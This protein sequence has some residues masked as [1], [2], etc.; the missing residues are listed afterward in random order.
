[1]SSF[2]EAVNTNVLGKLNRSEDRLLLDDLKFEG[3]DMQV[4][5]TGNLKVQVKQR[6]AAANTSSSFMKCRIPKSAEKK[7][8]SCQLGSK[9]YIFSTLMS[10]RQFPLQHEKQP[11]PRRL[12]RLHK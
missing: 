12:R 5:E 10:N 2:G 6:A 9:S 4:V 11:I 7:L 3:A 1:V 8:S